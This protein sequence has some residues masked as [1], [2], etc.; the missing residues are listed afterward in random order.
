V[1]D[2][3]ALAS[4]SS[5]SIDNYM[6][7]KDFQP[8]G[9]S[10]E[11]D[12]LATTFFE[13]KKGKKNDTLNIIR[14]V[15]LYKKENSYYFAFHTTCKN[16]FTDGRKKLLKAGFNCNDSSGTGQ[17]VPLT[18]Q[19]RNITV[20]STSGAEE[21]DPVYTFLLEKKE[22][23]NPASIRFADDLV[24]FTSHEYL[25]SF[26]G[27]KNVKKDVYYFSETK[28][29]KC[30]VL[31][32]H[33]SQQAVF[34]WEDEANL[35]GLSYVVVSGIL[36]T[37][38]AAQFTG[39]VP[40]N[41]WVLKSGLYSGMSMRELL[42]LNKSDFEFFGRD[43]DFSFMVDPQNDGAINFKKTGI[44]LGCLDCNASSLLSR[45]RISAADALENNLK[46]HVF[47]IMIAP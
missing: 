4:L 18:F 11:N 21:G 37:V 17:L 32:A 28:L 20:Q 33:S 26:F 19:K 22:L 44:M 29:R 30:S 42:E 9:K 34:V 41:R 12:A 25:V 5:K 13:K 43:S 23:P 14:T 8:A 10:M 38:S 15:S 24:R 45:T 39:S 7:K 35:S 3:V 36:P 31:F 16:E 6:G 47:Y 46:L 2:L 40:E 27:E 1:D